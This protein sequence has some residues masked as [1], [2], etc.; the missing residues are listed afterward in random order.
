MFIFIFRIFTTKK[1][2]IFIV[3]KHIFCIFTCI[4]PDYF[5]LYSAKLQNLRES[6]SY[7][8]VKKEKRIYNKQIIQ[9]FSTNPEFCFILWYENYHVSLVAVDTREI[10]IFIPLY[11]NRYCI[12]R[13]YKN[14]TVVK[15]IFHIL[16]GFLPDYFQPGSFK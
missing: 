3:V 14:L 16:T 11:E 6:L 15:H 4:L 8:D 1:K 13:K 12:C 7:C 2:I 5:P 9:I 10:S